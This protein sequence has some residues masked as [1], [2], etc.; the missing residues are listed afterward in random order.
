MADCIPREFLITTD[1][2]DVPFS[3]SLSLLGK[4]PSSGCSLSPWLSECLGDKNFTYK[5]GR[6]LIGFSLP[7]MAAT[8]AAV[9]LLLFATVY[10]EN[11][12]PG[13][14]YRSS[15]NKYNC[16]HSELT[17]FRCYQYFPQATSWLSAENNC[18]LLGGNLVSVQNYFENTYITQLAAATSPGPPNYWIGLN[19][20]FSN[21]WTWADGTN[22]TY[23][24][25]Y[26]TNPSGPEAN[27]CAAVTDQYNRQWT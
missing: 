6:L 5:R 2:F 27:Q 13:S 1:L 25:W 26:Y 23:L 11:C 14:T 4:L 10:G 21:Q 7:T 3:K 22:A 12:P 15:F 20:L 16:S 17:S 19:L 9:L 24:N 8:K 18:K